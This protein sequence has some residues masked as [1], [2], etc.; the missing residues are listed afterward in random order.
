M[1]VGKPWW[2]RGGVRNWLEWGRC[3]SNLVSNSEQRSHTHGGG[4]VSKH[5]FSEPSRA[6][7]IFTWGC[8]PAQGVGAWARWEGVPAGVGKVDW[9]G[10]WD[11]NNTKEQHYCI[12]AQHRVSE[13]EQWGGCGGDSSDDCPLR[14]PVS[15]SNTL[16]AANTPITQILV[17]KYLSPLKG[18][19]ASGK[20]GQFQN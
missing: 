18:T 17:S 6:R 14:G 5:R 10:G 3:S 20:N 16:I 11:Q 8:G 7:S 15:S 2:R 12:V 9:C 4:G 13:C 1:R 19:R